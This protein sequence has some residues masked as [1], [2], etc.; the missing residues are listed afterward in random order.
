MKNVPRNE[1]RK[2]GSSKVE[3]EEEVYGNIRSK[4][5]FVECQFYGPQTFSHFLVFDI[6]DEEL[7]SD[8]F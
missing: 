6:A 1:N 5:S 8:F 7:L 4:I 3:V 2:L